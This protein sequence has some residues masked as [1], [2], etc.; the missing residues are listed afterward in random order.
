MPRRTLLL[1]VRPAVALS[2]L[3]V[4][5][6]H[7]TP[8]G[9]ADA[10]PHQVDTGVRLLLVGLDGADWQ[11]AG[12]LIAAGRL[13]NLGTLRDNGA[14]GDLRSA[15]PTLSP[16]LW[17]SMATGKTP[18]QHGII[19]FLVRDP[20]TGQ[21]VPIPSTLRKTKAIWNIYSEA[22][23]T[24]DFIGWWATWPA[25]TIR[26]H[27][28]SDRAAYSLFGYRSRPEDAIGLVSPPTFLDQI[29]PLLVEES[30]IELSDLRRFAPVTQAEFD[31]ARAKLTGDPTRAYD[32][33]IN[34][35]VRILA[36]TRTYH[37]IAL[38]L[39]RDGKPD[40]LSVYYQ[41]I[42]VTCH[43][44]AHFIPPKPAW[45]DQK[46]FDKYHE[47]VANMYEYQ[48]ELLGE[49]LRAAGPGITTVV[50][51]D[52]G[53]LNG[54][55]R[56]DFP[57]SI[58]QKAGM[59]HRLYGILVLNGPPISKGRLASSSL[60]DVAPTLLY[61]SGLPV[62][63]DFAGRPILDAVTRDFQ[64]RYRL[65]TVPT[66]EDPGGRRAG[67]ES[68]PGS[69]S[70]LDEE[71]LARLRSLGYIAS[72]TISTRPM[73]GEGEAPASLTNMLN[74]ATLDLQRGDLQ[75]SERIVRSILERRPSHGESHQLLSEILSKQGRYD[76]A[77]SEARTALN[78]METPPERLIDQY[79]RLAGRR[80]A[81]REAETYFLRAVQ[82]Q[83]GRAEPWLGLG[84][85]RYLAGDLARA[86]S[87]FLRALE[88]NPR[89]VASVTG[90]YNLFKQGE[91][92]P[93]VQSGIEKAAA[94][95]PDSA[96]HRTLLGLVHQ[97]Q[98]DNKRAESELRRALELDPEHDAAISGLGNL[99][100][101]TGRIEEARRLLEGAV[102]R[103]G[104]LPEARL[105]LGQVYAKM[106]HFGEAV[107]ETTEV[108]KLEPDSA[109]AHAQMGMIMMMQENQ[110]E[111]AI[112][113]MRRALDLDPGLYELR[114]HLAVL[115]HDLKQFSECEAALKGALE[116]R[117]DDLEAHRLLAGL[118]TEM[119]RL[120]EAES[121]L[122]RLRELSGR[123]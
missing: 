60:Y 71:V 5:S 3:A 38:K 45:V 12:P 88:M 109:V 77:L 105:V 69:S 57:P 117:P 53:F 63:L 94:A 95:N 31:A 100:M 44:F 29:P 80:G 97:Q 14:W 114:L 48:D 21:D 76:E 73:G 67:S 26:G 99:L 86:L 1:Q 24:V 123:R 110:P 16:L 28:V 116:S 46:E 82:I 74:M 34:H 18:D 55:N 104:E 23:R 79:V 49:L 121:V 85:S 92:S 56:P 7:A 113:R 91:G 40:L 107:R 78:L 50:A 4:F 58:E 2:L 43:R 65:A 13:P 89:S 52:H 96:V 47:V 17:T 61:L 59:W 115:Y 8:L 87:S 112:E 108:L 15:T 32:D 19:D 90:L 119:G 81:L 42:D 11:I 75:S 37:A 30:E 10:S 102:R 25:E 22:G 6:S 33:A 68:L 41:A 54:S 35:L 93:E 36:S 72:S 101:S 20:R 111:A 103:R 64:S 9:S 84:L 51:S 83:G 120:E 66:W 98:K 118:Y 106:G 70:A 122:S 27:M 39:L 62:P